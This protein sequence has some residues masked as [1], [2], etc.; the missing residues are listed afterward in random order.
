MKFCWI[1][2]KLFS[3]ITNAFG[4]TTYTDFE[5]NYAGESIDNGIGRTTYTDKDDN[6]TSSNTN[7]LVEENFENRTTTT[8]DNFGNKYY[9]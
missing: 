6:V 3:L 1:S 2:Y 7:Y 4:E 5:G 9:H 8:N